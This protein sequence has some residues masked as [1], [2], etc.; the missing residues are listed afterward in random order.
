MTFTL[1]AVGGLNNRVQACLSHLSTHGP[2]DVIWDNAI[3]P[4]QSVYEPIDGLNFVDW[5]HP[6]VTTHG[7]P[8]EAPHDWRKHYALLRPI[9]SIRE[10][11][12]AFQ[13]SMGD[14]YV[15]FHSRKTD[16]T[17]LAARLG[18]RMTT[19]EEVFAFMAEYPDVKVWAACDNGESQVKFGAIA[20]HPNYN[21]RVC[22]GE[23][24]AGTEAVRDEADHPVN[25]SMAGGV[26]DSWMCV[27]AKHFLGSGTLGTFTGTV[28]ILRSLANGVVPTGYPWA[29]P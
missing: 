29:K 4:F 23:I 16:M 17:P 9:A 7:I 28:E 22:I 13:A 21:P 8:A 18:N 20:G 11:V 14:G 19:D 15:A 1:R 26:V 2:I 3:E 12:A 24:M 25:G 5:R 6:D 27:G 10:R